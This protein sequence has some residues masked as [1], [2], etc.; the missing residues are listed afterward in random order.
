M[1]GVGK[2]RL[3]WR[4]FGLTVFWSTPMKGV[5]GRALM[6][7]CVLANNKFR[8]A[9]EKQA[10]KR[11]TPFPIA[12][13]PSIRGRAGTGG[14]HRLILPSTPPPHFNKKKTRGISPPPNSFP[15]RPPPRAAEMEGEDDDY[16]DFA[17]LAEPTQHDSQARCPVDT[18]FFIFA[19][20]PCASDQP[21]E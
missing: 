6:G 13:H 5:K 20:W 18:C 19:H 11:R 15:N 10:F 16:D 9:R 17:W 7:P 3:L 21:P 1:K 14:R 8:K 2:W 4:S 12:P